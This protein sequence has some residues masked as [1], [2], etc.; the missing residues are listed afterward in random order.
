M[1]ITQRSR[2]PHGRR[3]GLAVAGV[4]VL[5]LIGAACGDDEDTAA[6]TAGAGAATGQKAAFCD[7]RIQLEHEFNADEPDAQAVTS[8]LD[9]M[10]AAAPANL[11]ANV[12]TLT[13]VLSS[14][15]ESGNDPTEDPAFTENVQ[16]ID[17]FAL[18]HCGFDTV[19]VTAVD[20][21]F[22]GLPETLDAGTTGVKLTNEGAEHHELVVVRFNDGD[23]TAL[24]DLLAMSEEEAVRHATFVGV[25]GADPG[26]WGSSFMDLETGRY[27]A[28]CP[29]PMGGEDGPPHFMQ[30]MAAEFE[31]S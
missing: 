14:A 11:A 30:G 3:T 1:A 2:H 29:I 17:E 26:S 22:E 12:E 7:A 20:Y 9:D 15:A 25:I 27:A 16:P 28:F 13:T 8:L 10:Q 6:D 23:T 19:E 31:V 21:R 18:G 4:V 5:A 24:D